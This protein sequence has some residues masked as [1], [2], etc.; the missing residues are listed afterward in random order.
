MLEKKRM[1][2]R[3]YRNRR[4]GDFLKELQLTEGRATGFPKIYDAMK[5]N[6]SP[7]PAFETDDERIYFLAVL[8]VHPDVKARGQA[9]GHVEGQAGGHASEISLNDTE[10]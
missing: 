8:P 4:I 6:G 3:E 1:A 2:S 9:G 5:R 7:K 10:I